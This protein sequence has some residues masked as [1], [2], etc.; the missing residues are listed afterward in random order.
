MFNLVINNIKYEYIKHINFDHKQYVAYADEKN[1]Y[2][3]EYYF[4]HGNL[5]LL[6]VSDALLAI[7]SKEMNL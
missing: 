6:S 1:I 3:S 4:D 2:I 7:I 5:I